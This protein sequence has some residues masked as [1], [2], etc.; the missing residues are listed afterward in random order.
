MNNKVISRVGYEKCEYNEQKVLGN[1]GMW[2]N[3]DFALG[4]V[5]E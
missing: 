3:K 1:W 5:G 4:K 2:I